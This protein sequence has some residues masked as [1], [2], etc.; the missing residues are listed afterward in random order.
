MAG[1][2]ENS[3]GVEKRASGF[4][5]RRAPSGAQRTRSRTTTVA[6]FK[7]ASAPPKE[8]RLRGRCSTPSIQSRA[9]R[10]SCW[11]R[12]NSARLPF[13]LRIP[14]ARPEWCS[15]RSPS[16]PRPAAVEANP[17]GASVASSDAERFAHGLAG[18]PEPSLACRRPPP[19]PRPPTPS[20]RPRPPPRPERRSAPLPKLPQ[21][22]SKLSFGSARSRP[23]S[24]DAAAPARYGTRS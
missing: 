3:L 23:G 15:S 18:A 7:T 12:C 8:P 19:R 16:C 21:L 10:V 11:R 20:P 22:L 13:L 4:V 6:A 9:S 2:R 5:L 17:L 1:R 14:L 24:E